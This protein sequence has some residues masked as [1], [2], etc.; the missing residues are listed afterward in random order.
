M[1]ATGVALTVIAMA[2][3]EPSRL[4]TKRKAEEDDGSGPPAKVPRLGE[5]DLSLDLVIISETAPLPHKARQQ[6]P[7]LLEHTS[8]ESQI[9]SLFFFFAAESGITGNVLC[10]AL[11]LVE[12]MNV[13]PTQEGFTSQRWALAAQRHLPLGCLYSREFYHAWQG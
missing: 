8:I 12:R 11:F 5:S 1:V 10:D 9:L 7:R 6:P 13:D 4:R 3:S 2:E